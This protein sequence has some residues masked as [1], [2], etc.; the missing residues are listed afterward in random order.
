MIDIHCHMLYGVDDG[1]E[2][3]EES[4]QMLK[5][6]KSQ[7]I[8]RI[9]LT[10]HYRHGMFQYPLEEI[11][12]HF[13][14]LKPYAEELN[15]KLYLGTEFHV[16]SRIAKYLDTGRCLTLADS[17]YVLTE[18]FYDISYETIYQAT[19]SLL[20]KGYIPI[21]AH[22]ERYKPLVED[23]HRIEELKKMGAYIQVN[24]DAVLGKDGLRI[25][26]YCKKLL[27]NRLVDF[28]ASDSHGV[29][30]RACHLRDCYQYIEKKYDKTYAKKLM[31]ENPKLIL[32]EP[33]GKQQ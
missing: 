29:K 32:R 30:K 20:M 18:Y 33:A 13:E 16:H 8:S 24:A 27:Q 3:I 25:K 21:I 11:W 15:I 23:I 9:I 14:E 10:P 12:E 26:G 1:P 22:V 4:I 19:N 17:P 28:I 31:C 7:G 5:D 2:K 6:A